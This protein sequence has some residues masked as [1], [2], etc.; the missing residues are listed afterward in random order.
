MPFRAE[1]GGVQLVHGA[2]ERPRKVVEWERSGAGL[3]KHTYAAD[4]ADASALLYLNPLRPL[5][6]P[7][8]PPVNAPS[9]Q[10]SIPAL[11]TLSG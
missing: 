2:C 10:A 4:C 11:T 1:A 9:F 8:V 7:T 6:L 3:A 5:L